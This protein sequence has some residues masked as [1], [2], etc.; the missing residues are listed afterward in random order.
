MDINMSGTH[1]FD[2][3]IEYNFDFK[4]DE[5]FKRKNTQSEFGEIEDDGTGASIF[6]TMK[7]T[8]S[9]YVFAYERTGA[10]EYIRRVLVAEKQTLKSVLKSEFGLFGRDT[11]VQ[12]IAEPTTPA[13]EFVIEWDEFDEAPEEAPVEVKHRP[14]PTSPAEAD[15][16]GSSRLNPEKRK[17]KNNNSKFNKFLQK[18]E[19]TSD[20]ETPVDFGI[21]LEDQLP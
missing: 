13:P 14:L 11:A 15:P 1:G 17:K 21:E 10:R 9:D 12:T 18:L 20:D 3:S 16:D 19:E 2:N 7:G 4:V 5:I 6:L 8:T